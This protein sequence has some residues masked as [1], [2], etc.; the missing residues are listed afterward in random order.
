MCHRLA[1]KVL[2]GFSFKY[3]DS[4]REKAGEKAANMTL[5]LEQINQQPKYRVRF[6]KFLKSQ[7]LAGL[8]SLL[9]KHTR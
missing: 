6:L 7:G 3:L 4:M 5:K 1:G 9:V 8:S 2:A